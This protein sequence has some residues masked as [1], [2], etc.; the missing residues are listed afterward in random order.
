MQ[1]YVLRA[2]QGESAPLVLDSPHSGSVFP[3]DFG[4]D[5]SERELRDGED[6]LI[7]ELFG[8]AP[9]HGA[10]LIAATIARTYVDVNRAAD[11]VDAEL[12]AGPWPHP[13]AA[14]GKSSLGKALVWRT[15]DDGRP[16]YARKLG[17]DEMQRRIDRVLR[18]YQAAVRDAIHAAHAAFGVAYHVNCHSMKA[19]AGKM[20]SDGEGSRRADVVLGDRDGT[21]C[22]PGFTALVRELFRAAGYSVKVNDPYKGVEL[23]R[24]FSAPHQGR[25]SLQIELNRALYMNGSELEKGANFDRLRADL[26][27]VIGEL[28][29]YARDRRAR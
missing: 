26:D 10:T 14:S 2:P 9:D 29:R 7:D 17:I 12:L 27:R 21:T 1:A 3:E 6:F 18:P 13:V 15:L 4:H 11:D 22:E 23:V 5:V 28:A 8:T 24:A 16:I 25:H 20:S 19:V